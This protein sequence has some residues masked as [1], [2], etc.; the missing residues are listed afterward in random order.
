MKKL[1]VI[2]ILFMSNY[3]WADTLT[4]R[5]NG[6]YSVHLTSAC[7]GANYT[8]VN[9]Q[10]FSGNSYVY[11]HNN[12]WL[13]HD[14]YNMDDHGSASGTITNV[15]ARTAVGQWD[16]G[17]HD[18]AV[19]VRTH[20]VNYHG[21]IETIVSGDY[22]WHTEDYP[23]NP[24]TGNAWTWDEIDDVIGYHLLRASNGYAWSYEYEI[25]VT[26][27]PSASRRIIKIQ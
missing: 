17:T 23:T 1:L 5:P 15:Q 19:G 10:N 26:Y 4:I 21:S 24:Y 18:V 7:G 27:T 22:E 11:T 3:C 2:L 6:N 12:T 13:H 25:V 9:D 16:S 14:Q 8:C 20:G